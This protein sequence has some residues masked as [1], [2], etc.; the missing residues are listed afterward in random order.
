MSHISVFEWHK[1]FISGFKYVE[2]DSKSGK[3]SA[4]IER[5]GQ[6]VR[7][8]RRLTVRMIA[9]QLDMKKECLEDYHSRVGHAENERGEREK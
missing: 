5:V 1:R 6:L 3:P 4:N 7:G 9:G 2:D 8:D